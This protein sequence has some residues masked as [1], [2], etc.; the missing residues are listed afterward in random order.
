MAQ[1]ALMQVL[2]HLPETKDKDLLVGVETTDDA[3]VYRLT[4]NLAII[5]T[6][7][8]FPPIVDDPYLF[9]QIAA[10]NAMSDVYAMGG[11]PRLA[12]NIV[13]FP[14]GLDIGIL[15]EII[16]G[17]LEKLQE[18][19]AILIG[20]HSIEDREIKYGLAVTGLVHPEKVVTNAGAKPGDILVLT[21]PLGVGVIT[22]ALK[23]GK[24]RSEDIKD[25][26]ESMKTLNAKAGR[27]MVEV[28][29]N[30]CTDITGF[31]LLGHAMEMASA[32]RVGMVFHSKDIPVFSDALELVKRKGTRPRTIQSNM[33]YLADRVRIGD[34]VSKEM[35]PLL[36]DPQTS[37]GFL[38]SVPTQKVEGL[39][40]G[41]REEGVKASVIGEVVERKGDLVILVE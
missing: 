25:V 28:G 26:F 7:D 6:V 29:V 32:S 35:E 27:V 4:D 23:A 34:G 38:I 9:G 1:K 21:K 41:L 2:H 13:G 10:A 11:T 24:V 31:G 16:R 12:M 18:A 17:G 36:Y 30:A 33:G 22:T 20:G 40:K 37:G 15:Q 14:R 5:N 19:G 39:L 8:F 3:G